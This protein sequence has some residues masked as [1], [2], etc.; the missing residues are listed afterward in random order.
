MFYVSTTTV[1][2]LSGKTQVAVG[3]AARRRKNPLPFKSHSGHSYFDVDNP[4]VFDYI[5]TEPTAPSEQIMKE[6]HEFRQEFDDGRKKGKLRCY[7]EDNHP[8]LVFGEIPTEP[9]YYAKGKHEVI[10]GASEID[11]EHQRLKMEKLEREVEKITIANRERSGELIE[12][13]VVHKYIAHYLGNLNKKHLELPRSGL[14]STLY[15][16]A[17]AAA[18][19]RSGEKDIEHHLGRVLSETLK[20]VK[21]LMKNNPL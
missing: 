20:E 21:Q 2:K 7:F 5:L 18:D 8:D 9:R 11:A 4:K 3:K 17:L 19:S 6:A 12:R 16:L 13:A 14:A 10:V 15:G 1:S